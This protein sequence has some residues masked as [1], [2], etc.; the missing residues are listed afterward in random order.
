MFKKFIL[1]CCS[2]ALFVSNQFLPSV[3]ARGAEDMKIESKIG[4]MM[5][6]DFRLWNDKSLCRTEE[7]CASS[8][9]NKI[10]SLKPVVEIND[11][12]KEII[13][14]YHIGSVV[15]FSENFQSKEQA[16]KL[17]DDLQKAAIDS[18]NPPLLICVDQEGGRVERFSFGRNRL[19]NNSE[20]CNPDE[21]FEKGKIIAEELAELGIN[22]DFAPVVDINSNPKNP[23]INVRSFG[24]NPQIVSDE[25]VAF[26]KGLHSKGIR[27]TAKHF[28]GHGDTD[29]DSHVGLPR[30]NKSLSD[31][32]QFEL[33]PFKAL[34]DAGVDMIMAAHIELPQIESDTII[35]EKD[36]KEIYIPAS[37]SKSILTD[38]L[39]NKLNFKGVIVTDAM[40]MKAISEN[41]GKLEA[42]KMAVKA[43][44]DMI[45][46]PVTL[47]SINDASKLDDIYEN[48]KNAVN[49][50]E[51]SLEQIN[52]SV[53][54][55][56]NLKFRK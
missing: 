29:V 34:I 14:K 18:G 49:N 51:L 10:S 47:R 4:Q 6:L 19:K 36:G 38:L 5:C 40:N 35:S 26:M 44:A 52:C 30:V 48:L 55:I 11:E 46:M 50:K 15:L 24:D 45:C 12:I 20:I 13:S 39:R 27:A 32:E 53:D 33:K 9:N 31:L 42:I 22:C 21:A 17:I 25:G 3:N 43:G 56:L 37:L 1:T 2:V 41:V 7:S 23:V 16:K 54:R 28:P 8:S